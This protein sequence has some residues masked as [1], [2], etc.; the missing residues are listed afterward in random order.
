MGNCISK[1]DK[2]FCLIFDE[3]LKN[4]LSLSTVF[5]RNAFD[6]Y[7]KGTHTGVHFLIRYQ[8]WKCWLW[9]RHKLEYGGGTSKKIRKKYTVCYSFVSRQQ[10]QNI[11]PLYWSTCPK[12]VCW[13][14]E[15]VYMKFSSIWFEKSR[16]QYNQKI[17]MT[18]VFQPSQS[19]FCPLELF[20]KLESNKNNNDDHMF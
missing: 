2:D 7:A 5:V 18:W 3:V 8:V 1:I 12:Q 15:K 16:L 9:I 14:S 11:L 13:V 17:S 20:S 19:N 4:E 6:K 10:T